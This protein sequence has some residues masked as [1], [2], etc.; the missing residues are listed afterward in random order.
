[1]ALAADDRSKRVN[2]DDFRK[3]A[4]YFMWA[5][6]CLALAA[7]INAQFHMHDIRFELSRMNGIIAGRADEALKLTREI[8][9]TED[10]S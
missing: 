5:F 10:E 7:V 4:F 2:A 8:N 1:M 3:A 6:F 9:H